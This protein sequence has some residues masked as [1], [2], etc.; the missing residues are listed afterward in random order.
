MLKFARENAGQQ[1]HWDEIEHFRS[2]RYLGA[3]EAV[4]RI[5]G[6]PFTKMSHAVEC[7]PFHLPDKQC[8]YYTGEPTRAFSIEGKSKLL[9][10]FKLNATHPEARKYTYADVNQAYR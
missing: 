4:F 1:F 9:A 6:I 3:F 7:L 8:V 5:F 2:L 10:W